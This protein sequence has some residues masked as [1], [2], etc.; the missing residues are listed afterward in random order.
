[1]ALICSLTAFY[2]WKFFQ[3]QR[4]RKNQAVSEKQ[5]RIKSLLGAWT[6]NFSL[7]FIYEFF[8]EICVCFLINFVSYGANANESWFL[9][10]LN[11]FLGL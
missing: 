10:S 9:W 1:M 3:A 2:A 6:L 11:L 7:R 5:A 8:L 4:R